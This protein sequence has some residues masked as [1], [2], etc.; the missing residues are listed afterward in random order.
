M[1]AY[2]F[3]YEY[4]YIYIFT[5]IY[6]HACVYVSMYACMYVC[7]HTHT[8]IIHVYIYFS[9]VRVCVCACVCVC[10]WV[11]LHTYTDTT[12]V[13]T[14][15]WTIV[16]T[17]CVRSGLEVAVTRPR[18]PRRAGRAR[19]HMRERHVLT[20]ARSPH[21]HRDWARPVHICT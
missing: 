18:R 15:R 6:I 21:L 12:W 7:T 9:H 5:Y 17:P 3:V 8:Y 14:S 1:H 2:L 11:R 20:R 19:P 16:F 13:Q 10:V 4:I